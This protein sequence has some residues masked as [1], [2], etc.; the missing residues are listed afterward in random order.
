MGRA[1]RALV[2]VHVE[3][4]VARLEL[5][6][7][8]ELE[9]AGASRSGEGAAVDTLDRIGDHARGGASPARAG[10]V[11]A[12]LGAA[13]GL[14]RGALVIGDAEALAGH[15]HAPLLAPVVEAV[16]VGVGLDLVPRA[17]EGGGEAREGEGSEGLV[18]HVVAA[19]E[20]EGGGAVRIE[21]AAA[22]GVWACGR[23]SRLRGSGR[24]GAAGETLHTWTQS[25]ARDK[26]EATPAWQRVL[27][28]AAGGK[29]RRQR[30]SY[31]KYKTDRHTF[32][33]S[34]VSKAN[35]TSL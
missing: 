34:K 26:M 8:G 21:L 33:L 19:V 16:G 15:L 28:R 5:E 24:S 35:L 23:E 2:A 29:L 6:E 14:V 13:E 10:T 4:A 27:R 7:E 25:L 18:E 17:V 22:K 11:L 9:G 30:R 32:C 12:R 31:L 20:G 3:G 1:P